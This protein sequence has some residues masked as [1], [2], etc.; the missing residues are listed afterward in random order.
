MNRLIYLLVFSL[1]ALGCSGV[2]VIKI[3]GE[4]NDVR[5]KNDTLTYLIFTTKFKNTKV[6]VSSENLKFTDTINTSP[7]R[8]LAKA[9]LVKH[10]DTEFFINNEFVYELKAK[11]FRKYQ[12]VYFSKPVSGKPKYLIE[13]T[14]EMRDFY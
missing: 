12:F 9:I 3:D 7:I 8:G 6:F 2:Q 5:I 1:M 10:E 13:L 14:N 4:L 11:D